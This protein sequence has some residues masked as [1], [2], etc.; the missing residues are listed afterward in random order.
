MKDRA[1]LILGHPGHELRVFRFVE[2]YKP[3]VYVLTDGSGSGDISRLKSTTDLLNGCGA[4]ISPI[5]GYYTDKEIYRV[6]LEKD[7]LSL[8]E[9][10]QKILLDFVAHD[11][12]MVAGDAVEGYNPTHDLCRY[13]I[14]GIVSR[15]AAQN[16]TVIKNFD[17]QLTGIPGDPGGD[18]DLAIPLSD[19]DFTRKYRAAEA[20][21]ELA[22]EMKAAVEQYGS[23]PFKMEYLRRLKPPFALK[24]WPDDAIP[25]Y[26]EYARDKVQKGIYKQV[27]S[28][29]EH[30]LPL[31]NNLSPWLVQ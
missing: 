4:E 7:A 14:N 11:I 22:L 19:E 18:D 3:R 21:R 13:L 8:S 20:Y 5:M 6:I 29:Q 12:N 26:E 2:I 30:M 27:I 23:D 16:E 25:F 15:A 31:I 17:F 28:F 10:A 1:A 24:T 9:L